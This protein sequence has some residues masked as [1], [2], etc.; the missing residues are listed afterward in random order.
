M[1]EIKTFED[2]ADELARFTNRVW[3]AAYEGQV[4]L[5]LWSEAFLRR[6]LLPGDGTMRDYLV[7]AYDGGKLVGFHPAR[8]I[9]VRLHGREIPATWGSFLTVDPEYR[10]QK[11]AQRMQQEFI[12]RHQERGARVNFGYLY[13]RS[14]K[15]LGQKFWLN[16]PKGTAVVRS[17][18]MWVRALDHAAT[19][20]FEIHRLESWGARA[21]SLVQRS[22][23]PP[24]DPTGIR[25]WQPEDTPACLALI[26]QAGEAADLAYLWD[27]AGLERYLSYPGLSQ[28][29]VLQGETGVAGL[30]NYTL[31]E[32]LGRERMMV[33]LI[34]RIAFGSLPGR[35][36]RRLLSAALYQMS[37]DGAKGAMML[38]DSWYGARTLLSAGFVPMH[39]E[40]YYIGTCM[41]EEVSLRGIRRIQALWR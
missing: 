21:M 36:R 12:R 29:V 19:A 13:I 14:A 35:D 3:Q 38:R 5:P 25:L 23:R 37:G 22:P 32:I 16:Q 17:L 11:I 4:L 26:H 27:S 20:R 28:T 40:Y 6:E 7:A 41:D 8:P 31:L 24:L 18:G 30:V 15:S 10:G 1:I 2:D 33:A 34:D 39:S 9:T